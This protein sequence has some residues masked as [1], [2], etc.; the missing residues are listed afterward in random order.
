M[1]R[2]SIIR[3]KK[4][5]GVIGD[6]DCYEYALVYMISEIRLIP[7]GLWKTIDLEECLEARIFGAKGE[8]HLFCEDD[9]MMAVTVRDLA[10]NS[11]ENIEPEKVPYASESTFAEK[12]ATD[13]TVTYIR[14]FAH[15]DRV[16]EIR[17][18]CTM[19]EH[20]YNKLVIRE[21]IAYD[22]DGQAYT[23]LTRLVGLQ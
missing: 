7:F 15:I 17:K 20:K 3:R 12:N 19:K 23:A 10:E 16:H 4:W 11:M 5:D 8:L 6:N 2:I 21:Y 9:E 14:S 1:S 22:G 18:N 13:N